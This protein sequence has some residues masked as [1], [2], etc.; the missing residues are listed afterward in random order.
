MSTESVEHSERPKENDRKIIYI[1]I[2]DSLKI[3]KAS[4][5]HVVRENSFMR[6]CGDTVKSGCCAGSQSN[7]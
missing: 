6:V 7:H 1:E 4:V 2:I 3:L 5:G